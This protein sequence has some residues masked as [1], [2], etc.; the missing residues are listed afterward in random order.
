MIQSHFLTLILT[1]ALVFVLGFCHCDKA[2][3]SYAPLPA[4]VPTGNFIT[5]TDDYTSTQDSIILFKGTCDCIQDSLHPSISRIAMSYEIMDMGSS[6]QIA[7]YDSAA[8]ACTTKYYLQFNRSSG[9]GLPGN[10]VFDST[11]YEFKG[12]PTNADFTNAAAHNKGSAKSTLQWMKIDKAFITIYSNPDTTVFA[13]NFIAQYGPVLSIN[14]VGAAAI[15]PNIVQ[16]IGLCYLNNVPLFDTLTI[17]NY[18]R[19]GITV[20]QT[21]DTVHYHYLPNPYI[22]NGGTMCYTK[23]LPPWW[24]AFIANNNPF[25][26]QP[27]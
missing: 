9:S 23:E 12:A 16:V 25:K 18:Y 26:K 13:S 14:H 4:T 2:T 15:A 27:S 10:W 5:E 11:S 8:A 20:Y 3:G 19:A 17:T 7:L 22:F 21:S 1:G 24:D 6:L